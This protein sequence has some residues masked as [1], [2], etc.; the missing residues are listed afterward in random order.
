MNTQTK[1]PTG[2]CPVCNGTKRMPATDEIRKY[3]KQSGWYGYRADD[4]KC[5]CTNCGTQY[6]FGEPTG[7][8]RLRPDGTP[9]KHEY[10]GENAGRCYTRYTCKHCNDTHHIDSGD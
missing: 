10:T 6:M 5:D 4:D 3:G 7:Q 8:V 1:H 9:C 2:T